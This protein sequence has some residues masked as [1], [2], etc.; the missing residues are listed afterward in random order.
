MHAKGGFRIKEIRSVFENSGFV[1]LFLSRCVQCIILSFHVKV[2]YVRNVRK[3]R[4][5]DAA[6]CFQGKKILLQ[7]AQRNIYSNGRLVR[8]AVVL[9]LVFDISSQRDISEISISNLVG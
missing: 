1:V 9:R 8:Q 2:D 7:T 6:C 3:C 4:L 5:S